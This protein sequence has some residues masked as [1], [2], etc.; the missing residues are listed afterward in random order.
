MDPGWRQHPKLTVYRLGLIVVTIALGSAKALSSPASVTL[1]WVVGV[2]FFLLVFFLSYLDADQ[3]AKPAWLFQIDVLGRGSDSSLLFDARHGGGVRPRLY[4]GHP[5]LTGYRLLVTTTA[6]VFGST[7]AVLA[8]LG[9][10]TAP[11]A[12]EWVY[13]VAVSMV[14][15]WVGLHE[16]GPRETVPAFFTKDRRSFGTFSSFTSSSAQLL[17][18]PPR[19]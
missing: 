7:K 8:Y 19:H 5:T 9:Y 2:V 18:P 16:H 14:L 10:T 3:S 11:R 4:G 12:I 1:E 17:L 13:G 15:Y 6:V